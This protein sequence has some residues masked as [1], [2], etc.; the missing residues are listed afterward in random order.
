MPHLISTALTGAALALLPI[1]PVHATTLPL[2]SPSAKLQLTLT[3]PEANTSSTRK[4]LLICDPGGGT[5]SGGGTHPRAKAACRELTARKGK[6]ERDPA[7][8][9]CTLIYAPIVAKAEGHWKG[10]SVRFEREYPNDCAMRAHTG[11]VFL[12]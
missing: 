12:F 2:T 3:S 7:S 1:T 11:K 6:I 8:T 5:H 9:M 4:A 10:R